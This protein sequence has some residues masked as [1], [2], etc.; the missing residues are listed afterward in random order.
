MSGRTQASTPATR[1][2]TPRVVPES[3]IAHAHSL[4]R[5][6]ASAPSGENFQ[7]HGH[8][9]K[10]RIIKA[11]TKHANA[12]QYF[13]PYAAGSGT[14]GTDTDG[15]GAVSESIMSLAPH[16]YFFRRISFQQA[17]CFL[18]RRRRAAASVDVVAPAISTERPQ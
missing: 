10:G 17:R 11:A 16:R 14:S 6:P 8:R 3:V 12:L 13:Q 4:A 5:K 9:H 1:T 15:E 18:K 7:A 2:V